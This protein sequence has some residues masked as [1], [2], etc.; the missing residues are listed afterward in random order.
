MNRFCKAATRRRT[1]E[2]EVV[3]LYSKVLSNSEGA[4]G[5]LAS[6][7]LI[8]GDLLVP[9]FSFHEAVQGLI[10]AVIAHLLYRHLHGKLKHTGTYLPLQYV[11]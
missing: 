8:L 3:S 10:V 1:P 7:L 2:V 4:A 5:L 9:D 6:S 11:C